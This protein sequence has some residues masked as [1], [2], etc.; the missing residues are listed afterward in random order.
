MVKLFTIILKEDLAAV[1]GGQTKLSSV[2]PNVWESDDGTRELTEAPRVPSDPETVTIEVFFAAETDLSQYMHQAMDAPLA[3]KLPLAVIDAG[4]VRPFAD[5]EMLDLA[6]ETVRCNIIPSNEPLWHW[7]MKTPENER[8]AKHGP[9][10]TKAYDELTAEEK[11][12]GF[13]P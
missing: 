12:G 7:I 6:R 9:Y 2:L 13:R 3:Y 5:Q 1:L 4:V 10:L 8:E 11:R